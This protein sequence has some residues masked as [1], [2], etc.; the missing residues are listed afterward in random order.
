MRGL[1]KGKKGV[2]ID[3]RQGKGDLVTEATGRSNV[4]EGP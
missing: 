1:G 2:D 4:R 3:Y